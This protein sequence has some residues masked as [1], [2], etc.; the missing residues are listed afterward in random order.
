MLL[1]AYSYSI[2]YKPTSSH[3][4]ADGLSRLPLPDE[5]VTS[6]SPASFNV[7]QVQALPVSSTL[8]RAAT[9]RDPILSRVLHYTKRGWP[10]NVGVALKPYYHRKHELTVEDECL[11]WG[12]RVIVP[13]TLR[14]SVMEELHQGHPGVSRMKAV[15]RSFVWWPGLDKDLELVASSCK[16]CKM[17]KQAPAKAPLHP[18]VWPSKQ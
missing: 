2:D 12:F 7:A 4:N 10:R 14:E 13:K 15:A 3:G 18:W 6:S 11:L 17:V 5:D 1:S 9:R 8:V 16:S